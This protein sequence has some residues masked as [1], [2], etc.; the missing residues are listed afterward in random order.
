MDSDDERLA[1]VFSAEAGPMP[2]HAPPSPVHVDI[3]PQ[4]SSSL[5]QVDTPIGDRVYKKIYIYI[6]V[7][8]CNICMCTFVAWIWA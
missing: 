5:V 6:Y 1:G 8:M 3:P 7:Y 2:S 4:S